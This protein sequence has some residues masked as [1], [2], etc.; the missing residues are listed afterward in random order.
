MTKL[1]RGKPGQ[2]RYG[3]LAS[4]VPGL[5]GLC[6]LFAMGI[7]R[8]LIDGPILIVVVGFIG[9]VIGFVV[10]TWRFWFV[11]PKQPPQN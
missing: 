6:F 4:M 10:S 3:M 8:W 5:K 11:E 9:L 2:H 7:V 1:Q